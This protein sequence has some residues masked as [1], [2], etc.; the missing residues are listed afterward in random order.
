[1]QVT[2]YYGCK[3]DARNA[4]DTLCRSGCTQL[5]I[6]HVWTLQPSTHFCMCIRAAAWRYSRYDS[7]YY[8]SFDDFS[9][10]WRLTLQAFAMP[11]SRPS[12]KPV[13]SMLR[14]FFTIPSNSPFH[15]FFAISFQSLR[16]ESRTRMMGAADGSIIRWSL[17]ADSRRMRDC[18]CRFRSCATREKYKTED[19]NVK[20]PT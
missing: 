17:R 12:R 10:F 8:M 11:S 6:H 3:W 20:L 16:L 19:V 13:Q 5:L 7:I 9:T 15:L 1:M 14:I 18:C 4:D 2:I